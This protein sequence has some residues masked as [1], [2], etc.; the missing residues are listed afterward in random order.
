MTGHN[1]ITPTHR[2]IR[3]YYEN[4]AALRAQGVLNEMSVRSPFESLLQETARLKDWTFIAELSGKSGGAL[5]RPDGTLRDRNSL[6]RGYWEAKDT[7]DDLDTEIKKKIARGYPLSNIIFE[8]TQTGV[9][10]Q[11]KQKINGP[12]TLG[13]PKEL[14]ALL[15]QFFSYTEPDIEGFEEA[16]DEFKERVPD[17]A[18][19]LVE[20]I[21]QAHKDNA[22]FQAAFEKFFD[23]CRTAL[24]PNIRVEAVDEMLVQHLLTER[25]F[26]TV[27]NN[28][29]FVKRNAIAAEVERVIEALVGKSFD[30]TEYL[31]SL[32]RF[33]RAI[34]GAARLLPDF[35]E[36]QHFLNT[37]YERFFQG[38]SVKLADTHGIVYT[39][40]EI[41]N[42]MCA[43][44]A[45]VLKKEFG[46]SLSSPDVY[47]I[48]PCTGTG[49]FIVNLLRRMP[50]RDLPRVYREQLFANEVMLLPY[51]IASLN[52][53]HAYYE[54]T[55]TYEPFDGLC[56]VDTLDLA[57]GSQ[58]Q[59][60][61]MTVKNA[62]R[63]ARQ[64]KT[65]ITV[66]IGNP[67]Y[68]IG[69]LNENDNNKNRKYQ[70]LDQRVQETYVKDSTATSRTALSDP[71]VR[72][73]RW[74]TDRL[75]ERDGVVC[76][77]TNN[78]FL[79]G[80]AFDGFR[81][82]LLTEFST[83]YHFD[84]RGNARTTGE[85]RR[86]EAGNIFHDQIRCGVGITVLVRKQP[87]IA[88]A[89]NYH[90]VGAYW[91][92]EQ[93]AGYLASF[94]S[95]SAVPWKQL[96]PDA[97]GSW[98]IPEYSA[99]F[100]KLIPIGSKMVKADEPG[101]NA[102]FHTYS[103][104]VATCRDDVVYDFQNDV[105]CN[106]VREFIDAY[107]SEVD[108]YK[109]S[110][111]KQPVDEFVNYNSI[112]WS[113]DLKLDLVRGKYAQ[114]D[115]RK[116]RTTLYR[117]FC[118]LFLFFDRILNEEVYQLPR[119]LP[120]S[121]GLNENQIVCSTNHLQIPFSCQMTNCLPDVAVGG[122]NGQCFPFYVYDEDGTN[123]RE[124]I[125]DW[126]LEQFRKHYTDKKITKWDIFYYVYGILHHP[127]YRAKYAENLK[128]ELP[129]IPLIGVA[130][131]SVSQEV[132]GSS[133]GQDNSRGVSGKR[134]SALPDSPGVILRSEATKNPGSA[135]N[136]NTG[137]LRCAQNDKDVFWAFAKAG[138]ELARLHIDYE[139]VE[140]WPLKFI[141][142]TAVAAVSD[143]RP[144]VG[145]PPLQDASVA[146][147]LP[148]HGGV[149]P[150]LR[151]AD[152]KVGATIPLSYRV[153]DKMRLA[154]DH[155]SLKVNDS[156]T[157]GG[158]PPETFEY[159]LGNRSALEW[160]IDQYQV[161]EDKHSGIRSDPNR[162]AD[163]EY[164]VRLVGQVIRVSLETVRL[165]KSLPAL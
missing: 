102:V 52:I 38:Y 111:A 1:L 48:D 96:A 45:E 30:R 112:K 80:I 138:K 128:R 147:S 73:F 67:P 82:H 142:T 100:D 27:F 135:E 163:P 121:A 76:F 34:E 79:P 69:Q 17:L 23:L 78:G 157:L 104:G 53:E 125:T 156:L 64:R 140:P 113:R 50:G 16:V 148:R 153:E 61:F 103:R 4:V 88:R 3:K 21:Q 116:A 87:A 97:H 62:E 68:N 60:G 66:V 114:F 54:L 40:Q 31:K 158:I 65:P 105:L 36:K 19:G 70:T 86:Q 10:F 7:Q 29:E 35:S 43:S 90:A 47:I 120:E 37:V 75:Q 152:L 131:T 20:K 25:L 93:K 109:R 162:P 159:R 46:K 6:P 8:D 74:A 89:V 110:G 26:R 15:N 92:A 5:I 123:R 164:I 126:A 134:N 77:V 106:R 160:V 145:T 137:V 143:R 63:V 44:V 24:N 33:Y 2:S 84:L 146:A 55:G 165:V 130:Q 129:R 22:P 32:D 91:K 151:N 141:E 41:V 9:L 108:R 28:P 83:I 72:F 107:N 139:K 115:T 99:E 117:P 85:R 14:V 133:A 118:K 124:N 71:Y 81:K 12:Y 161:T 59:L 11:S 51:Y 42:F 57:E 18:R 94:E 56:F 155:R 122:R 98:L 144:A 13:N 132:C 95:I 58:H 101:A 149:K 127:G 150:P 154:K 136:A 119:I 49:N 39:P